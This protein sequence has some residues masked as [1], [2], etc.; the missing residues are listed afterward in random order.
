M[1]QVILDVKTVRKAHVI[2]EYETKEEALKKFVELVDANKGSSVLKS[3][4]Y[5]IRKKP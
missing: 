3:G 5:T 1:Y 4:N 2:A